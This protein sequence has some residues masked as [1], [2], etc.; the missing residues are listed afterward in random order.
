MKKRART[1]RRPPV[2]AIPAAEPYAPYTR[3]GRIPW[4]LPAATAPPEAVPEPQSPVA[5]TQ[6][7]PASYKEWDGHTFRFDMPPHHGYLI[8]AWDGDRL[9][10]LDM[11]LMTAGAE[12]RCVLDAV[13][14]PIR[15][16]IESGVDAYRVIPL[17]RGTR[18]APSGL[19]D[20]FGFVTSFADLLGRW[21]AKELE[22]RVGK[23]AP[24][25]EPL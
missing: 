9:T 3:R 22:E 25:N 19:V 14:A 6:P 2:A 4:T 13:L 10:Y 5:A 17:L 1:P 11:F 12:E 20:G 16:L 24:E 7:T 8:S 18:F 23:A 15:A 21:I